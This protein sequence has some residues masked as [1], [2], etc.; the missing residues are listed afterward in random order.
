[1]QRRRR[2]SQDMGEKV[3]NIKIERDRER[4]RERERETRRE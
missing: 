3:R 4:E 2:C 1:L